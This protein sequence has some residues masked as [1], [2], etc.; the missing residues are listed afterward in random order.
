M[1]VYCVEYNTRKMGASGKTEVS[2]KFVAADDELSALGKARERFNHEGLDCVT[3]KSV[4]K[5]DGKYA[6]NHLGGECG[7]CGMED[8]LQELVCSDGVGWPTCCNCGGC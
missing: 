7:Y 4:K 8:A 3:P 6:Y 1:I 2:S 5:I